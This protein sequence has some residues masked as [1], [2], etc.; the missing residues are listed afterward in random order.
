MNNEIKKPICLFVGDRRPHVLWTKESSYDPKSLTLPDWL[1]DTPETREHWA[2]YLTDIS[3]M[4]AEMGQIYEFAKH[5]FGDDFLFL[6]SSDDRD[7]GRA[8]NGTC[9]TLELAYL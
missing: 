9:T 7:S 5:R 6:F 1:I 3:G 8:G 4:D 2:R